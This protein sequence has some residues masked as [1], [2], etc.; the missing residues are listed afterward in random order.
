M[1]SYSKLVLPAYQLQSND[2]SVM[3]II[4]QICTEMSTVFLFFLNNLFIDLP[5]LKKISFNHK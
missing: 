3:T 4:Y 2:Y 1:K 5:K